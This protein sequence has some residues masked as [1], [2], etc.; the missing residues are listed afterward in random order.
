MRVG[1]Q[2]G[3]KTIPELLTRALE[4]ENVYYKVLALL[5]YQNL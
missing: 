1:Y 4:N 2:C 3:L 5:S